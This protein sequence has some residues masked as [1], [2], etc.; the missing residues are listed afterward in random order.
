MS[1]KVLVV[2]F[3]PRKVWNS[4][5][6]CDAFTDGTKETGNE[7]KEMRITELKSF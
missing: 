2:S 3:L 5:M 4:D 7:V 6:L 1:K